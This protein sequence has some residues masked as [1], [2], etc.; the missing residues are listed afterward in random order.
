MWEHI[1]VKTE[2]MKRNLILENQALCVICNQKLDS[3]RH[4]SFT[5]DEVWKIWGRWCLDWK[6]NWV[7]HESP[8][9]LFLAWNSLC[10]SNDKLKI[11]IL[12]FYVITWSI[13]LLHNNIVLIIRNGI[14]ISY[15]T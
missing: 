1:S 4:L 2:L 14:V 11:W 7:I 5:C 9:F 15:M 12:V 3:V 10:V 6:V 8:K 13:W